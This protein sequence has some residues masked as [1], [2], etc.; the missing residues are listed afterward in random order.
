MNIIFWSWKFWR[1]RKNKNAINA[2]SDTLTSFNNQNPSFKSK[3]N[4]L[5][6]NPKKI[7]S[8]EIFLLVLTF[9]GICICIYSAHLMF[10][11]M[12]EL[13]SSTPADKS[14]WADPKEPMVLEFDRPVLIDKINFRTVPETEGEIKYIKSF[15]NLPFA[16]KVEFYPKTNFDPET[17]LYIY[18]DGIYSLVGNH[19]RYGHEA[20]IEAYKIPAIETT[21]LT[22]QNEQPS[23]DSNAQVLEGIPV[24]S[25]FKITLT[26]DPEDYTDFDFEFEPIIQFT[27]TQNGREISLKPDTTLPQSAK[28]KLRITRTFKIIDLKTKEVITKSPPE[29]LSEINFETVKA[30]EI[31]SFAPNGNAVTVDSEIKF[32]F[33]QSMQN[34]SVQKNLVV[35]PA[36]EFTP[37]WSNDDKTLVLQ[38]KANLNYGTDYS[39][40][41]KAGSLGKADTVLESDLNYKFKT[42]GTAQVISV[43]PGNGATGQSIQ[44]QI[45]IN[46]DQEVDHASAQSK[47]SIN[48]SNAGSFSWDGNTMI[49]KPGSFS[50]LTKYTY[51]IAAGVKS[52]HGQDSNRAYS[53]N[54]TTLSQTVTL[55]VPLYSQSYRFSCNLTAASMVLAYKGVSRSQATIY[56][57]IPKDSTPKANGVWG[58]PDA[59]YVGQLDGPTGYGIHWGPIS[60]Y[61]NSQGVSARVQRG[62]SAS[63]LAKE[64][65]QGH[66]AIV[67]VWNTIS[68]PTWE[69]WTTPGGK[70]VKGLI[71]MHSYVVIGYV[72]SSDN[73]SSII[74]NDPWGNRRTLTTSRFNYLWSF[75][76]NTAVIVS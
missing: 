76:G 37:V 45:R 63:A 21:S 73:P 4:A 8:L 6:K 44:T 5:I 19:E 54:F 60:N 20:S 30:P 58:D 52:V 13:T 9:I 70:Q 56:S 26:K 46:F 33:T 61:I 14:E 69:T 43:S 57:Q 35:E 72:G 7:T 53:Y 39:I 48:P 36:F 28:Y 10:N 17:R 18:I 11:T 3:L 68:G 2:S 40:T 55:S 34:E 74:V 75:Y 42:I 50:Y 38:R 31:K 23:A 64:I 12:P 62:M 1:K 66:P 67:W 27:K 16:R 41:L 25:D 24:N 47:F 22:N 49:F 51:T 15:D 71:G 29:I 59:G 65:E 32:E